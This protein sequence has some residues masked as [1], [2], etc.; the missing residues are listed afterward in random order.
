MTEPNFHRTSLDKIGIIGAILAASGWGMAGIFIQLLPD[1]S[2]FLI[3]AIRL[4]LALV[5]TITALLLFQNQLLLHIKELRRFK[6]WGFSAIMLTCYTC[7]T[8]AFQLAPVGEVS[9]LMA[10]APIFVIFFKLLLRKQIMR[11]EY[12][13]ALIALLGICFVIFPSLTINSIV[14]RQRIVGN[15]LALLF[16]ALL[17]IYATWFRYLSKHSK[18][19]SSIA[20][21]LGTFMLGCSVFLPAA[22]QLFLTSSGLINV[23]HSIAFLGLGIA[24]TA[25]P[26]MSY[27]VAAGRLPPLMTTSV[28]LLEPILA[29][30]FAFLIL[31]EVPSI[32]IVPGTI[33]VVIGLLYTYGIAE[34]THS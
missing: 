11:N 15:L 4:A 8:L 27:A 5:V 32:W 24:S 13:G 9:L 33:L 25:I 34:Q 22:L 3:V 26:T 10:T 1:F 31:R 19:P 20:V 2:V 30:A 16:S 28:L 23:K 6:V 14:S 18:A 21:A 17:A 7:G 12:R 29:T